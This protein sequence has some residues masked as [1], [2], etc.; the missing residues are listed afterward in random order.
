[1]TNMLSLDLLLELPN[2]I[3]SASNDN[4]SYLDL[5]GDGLINEYFYSNLRKDLDKLFQKFKDYKYLYSSNSNYDITSSMNNLNQIVINTNRNNDKVF[6]Y[7][8]KQLDMEN[9]INDF[10]K[11]LL[12]ISQKLTD[13]EAIYLVDT[14]FSSKSEEFISEKLKICKA[15]LQKIKKSCL[16]KIYLEL[17]CY[18]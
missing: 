10:Y 6:N 14:F 18:M 12:S 11:S 13:A 3:L 4:T 9:W 7:V 1:M 16:V 15:S 5:L 17:N 8:T 2:K